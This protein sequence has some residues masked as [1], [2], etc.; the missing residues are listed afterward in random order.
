[1]TSL[2]FFTTIAIVFTCMALVFVVRHQRR[3]V[4]EK[5]EHEMEHVLG[6][7]A[8]RRASAKLKYMNSTRKRSKKNVPDPLMDLFGMEVPTDFR[9]A[10]NGDP[11]GRPTGFPMA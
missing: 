6:Q 8:M 7:D 10:A 4:A 3:G 11:K 1:M 9:S 5:R 2:F